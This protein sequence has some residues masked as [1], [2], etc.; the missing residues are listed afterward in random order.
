VR[1]I[2]VRFRLKTIDWAGTRRDTIEDHQVLDANSL[3]APLIL[4][5]WRPGDAYTPHGR[6]QPRKLKQMFLAARIP[7]EARGKWPVLESAG[8]VIWSRGMPA[9]D[10]FCANE[11]TRVGLVIEEE[12]M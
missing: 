1:E 2:G 10:G 5:N 9:A 6:R 3:S 7:S 4:R 11:G 12:G 8:R